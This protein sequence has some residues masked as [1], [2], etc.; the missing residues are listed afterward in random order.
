MILKQIKKKSINKREKGLYYLLKLNTFWKVLD[1]Y[2]YL[3][4]K[5]S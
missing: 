1:D 2:Y 3:N 4:E 5:N